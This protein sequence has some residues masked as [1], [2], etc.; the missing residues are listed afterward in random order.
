MKFKDGLVGCIFPSADRG[1]LFG[2]SAYPEGTRGLLLSGPLTGML[3]SAGDPS[4]L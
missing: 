1:S 4:L 2:T 3:L